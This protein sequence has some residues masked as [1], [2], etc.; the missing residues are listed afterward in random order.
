MEREKLRFLFFSMR[1]YGAHVEV[2]KSRFIMALC[3]NSAFIRFPVVNIIFL[4]HFSKIKP[5]SVL[6]D[7]IHQKK[8]RR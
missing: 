8:N 5:M 4:P 1:G 3:L 2:E 6:R 7:V